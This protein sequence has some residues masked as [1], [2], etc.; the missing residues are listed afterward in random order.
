MSTEEF[1]EFVRDTAN[2]MEYMSEPVRSTRRVLGTWVMIYLIFFLII[3]IMLKKQIW[4]D[5]T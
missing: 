4:K 3:A 5:V 1:D 2:F